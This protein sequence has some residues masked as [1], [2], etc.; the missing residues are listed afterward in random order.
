MQ[1]DTTKPTAPESKPVSLSLT[2]GEFAALMDA[3]SA[4]AIEDP[5]KVLWLAIHHYVSQ[6]DHND[7][8]ARWQD[9]AEVRARFFEGDEPEWAG[10]HYPKIRPAA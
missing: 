10:T 2:A 3:G 5:A 7:R 1:K 4:M 9:I 6:F 8:E